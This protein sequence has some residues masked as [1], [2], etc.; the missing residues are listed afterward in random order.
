MRPP[1]AASAA[2]RVLA[3]VLPPRPPAAAASRRNL[4]VATAG[5]AAAPLSTP[6]A[7]ATEAARIGSVA[8]LRA[9]ATVRS[10]WCCS[11][12]DQLQ[13]ASLSPLIVHH[14]DEHDRRPGLAHQAGCRS[15]GGT[16]GGVGD[17]SNSSSSSSGSSNESPTRASTSI[18]SGLSTGSSSTGGS[19]GGDAPFG[20]LH[21]HNPFVPHRQH[22]DHQGPRHA[23]PWQHQ[24][25]CALHSSPL[26]RRTRTPR[27]TLAAA[28]PWTQLSA[29]ELA[30]SDVS[31]SEPPSHC[32][33]VE[34]TAF[35]RRYLTAA[36]HAVQDLMM[37]N[38]APKAKSI[39]AN[40]A[41]GVEHM[42]ARPHLCV[43]GAPMHCMT[44]C[45]CWRRMHARH[46]LMHVFAACTCAAWL[47]GHMTL[48]ARKRCCAMLACMCCMSAPERQCIHVLGRC[49]ESVAQNSSVCGF[50]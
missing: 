25:A 42:Q 18:D 26:R 16:A 15:S 29:A 34:I 3:L 24:Q 30:A 20:L 12:A 50:S 9:A 43:C 37:I 47:H 33:E 13:R 14:A 23:A 1:N 41:H 46:G 38:L 6:A 19:R 39:I 17:A 27:A 11:A 44:A 49:C 10:A 35:E 4:A 36:A 31:S 21:H 8:M 28:G 48:R 40:G 45:M 32:I 2:W 5:A 7:A 22:R